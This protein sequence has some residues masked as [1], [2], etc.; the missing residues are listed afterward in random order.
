MGRKLSRRLKSKEKDEPF[1]YHLTPPKSVFL[2]FSPAS[3]F[4]IENSFSRPLMTMSISIVG[5]DFP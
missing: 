4:S 3:I 2:N 1:G 5:G